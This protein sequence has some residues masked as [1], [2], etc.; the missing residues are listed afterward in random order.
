MRLSLANKLAATVVLT[1]A[2]ALA[3]FLMFTMTR[4]SNSVTEKSEAIR[5]LAQSKAEQNLKLETQLVASILDRFMSRVHGAVAALATRPEMRDAAARGNIVQID[6]LLRDSMSLGGLHGLTNHMATKDV[7]VWPLVW[8][9]TKEESVVVNVDFVEQSIHEIRLDEKA[10][11][12]K[13]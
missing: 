3:G 2:I 8:L 1:V 12:Q 4:L 7:L 9:A 6:L 10:P 11:T 5:Q 13:E